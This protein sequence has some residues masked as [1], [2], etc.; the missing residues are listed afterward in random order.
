MHIHAVTFSEGEEVITV[1]RRH[2]FSIALRAAADLSIFVVMAVVVVIGQTMLAYSTFAVD[3]QQGLAVGVY[4]LAFVGLLLWMHFFAAWSDHWLDA[5]IITNK[6]IIDIEQHGFFRR[7]VSSFP[8]S[9]IQDVTYS[10]NGVI[11]M[12]L[13]FGN[14]RIQTASISDDLI[15]RQVPF[16]GDVKETIVRILDRLRP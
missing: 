12:W 2:W 9:R 3:L 10:M 5:W 7:Q 15:M 8:L 13:K 16:P 11:A 1:I 14:V 4:V 6:R